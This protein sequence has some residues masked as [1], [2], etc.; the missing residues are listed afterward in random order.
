MTVS[1][2]NS[3][4]SELAIAS[5]Q[6]LEPAENKCVVQ[7]KAGACAEKKTESKGFELLKANTSIAL[8]LTFVALGGG[9]LALY[10]SKI[11][12]IPEIEWSSTLVYLAAA[13]I[14]GAGVGIP[15]AMSVLLPGIIWSD[16]L[17][18]DELLGKEFALDRQKKT[19]EPC[20][21]TVIKCLGVPFFISL[22]I[23]HLLLRFGTVAYWVAAL[24][25]L[26]VMFFVMR[27]VCEQLLTGAA[28]Q[29]EPGGKFPRIK[30]AFGHF[31]SV[32]RS[33]FKRNG[34]LVGEETGETRVEKTR[35]TFLYAF[36]F[37]LSILLSQISMY[38]IYVM[39]GRP[40][41]WRSF[42]FR[43][44]T[45]TGGVLISSHVVALRYKYHQAQAIVAALVASVVLVY[46]ADQFAPVS[47]SVMNFYGIGDG[48]TVD[49]IINEKDSANVN[50]MGLGR[51]V[52]ENGRK[53]QNVQILSKLGNEYFVRCY[54]HAFI[55][56]KSAVVSY[57]GYR[58]PPSDPL[59]P[60]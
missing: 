26:L 44:I 31:L 33:S 5:N 51:C 46:T 16:F 45:C 2:E 17:I 55:L 41:D 49:M 12:Y 19:G 43:T 10:Y 32:I 23:S 25:Q 59:T 40:S 35:Y 47:L 58:T 18:H 1:S 28:Q 39:S 3:Q 8:W 30:Q 52:K 57:Q 20:V 14:I 29:T 4:A 21:R 15:L 48:F 54:D 42:L 13:S 6:E 7:S 60:N 56:P 53:L 34:L 36:W 11:G 37:D 38:L 50:A 9:L 27:T 22:V 24:V